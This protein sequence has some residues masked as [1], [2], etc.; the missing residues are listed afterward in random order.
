[1]D[2]DATLYTQIAL[3]VVTASLVIVTA[4]YAWITNKLVKA[5]TAP[6]PFVDLRK[7]EAER[8]ILEAYVKNAGNSIAYNLDFEIENGFNISTETVQE[9]FDKLDNITQLAPQ[10]ER[11]LAIIEVYDFDENQR[12]ARELMNKIIKVKITYATTPQARSTNEIVCLLDFPYYLKRT[13]LRS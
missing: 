9:S 1:M 7:Q 4:I 12:A 8:Q 10:Q 3:V 13:A 5:Q 6:H 2:S 11:E